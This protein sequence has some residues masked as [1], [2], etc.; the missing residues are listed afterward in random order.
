MTMDRIKIAVMWV[1]AIAAVLLVCAYCAKAQDAGAVPPPPTPGTVLPSPQKPTPAVAEAE[2]A[3]PA[4]PQTATIHLVVPPAAPAP[5]QPTT[6]TLQIHVT[7]APPAQ[8]LTATAVPTSAT[9][10]APTA[11]ELRHPG[12]VRRAV[13]SFGEWLA[14]LKYDRLVLRPAAAPTAALVQPVVYQVPVYAPAA[15]AALLAPAPQ[16][17]AVFASPQATSK[18]PIGALFRR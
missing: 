14:P 10:P 9:V 8:P 7:T 3:P 17:Q 5:P 4:G 16:P 15:P 12:P 2:T 1:I 6:H 11:A 18:S 13:G